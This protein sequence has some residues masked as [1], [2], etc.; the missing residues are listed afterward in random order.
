MRD[1][2]Q[3]NF[4]I[5]YDFRNPVPW[6]RDPTW[7]YGALVDQ[8]VAAEALGYD[9]VWIS[10]HH[11][12]EDGYCPAAFPVLGALA[13]RT[14]QVTLGTHVLLLP[15]HHP[16]R[17]AE[18]SAVADVLSHGRLVLGAGAGYRPEEFAIYQIPRG[19]R[20]SRMDEALEI[21]RLA[22]SEDCFSFVGQHF[23]FRDVTVRPRPAQPDGIPI[24]LGARG[25]RAVQRAVRL[26]APLL[27]AGGDAW[28]SYLEAWKE[29][30][31][32]PSRAVIA[33]QW[34][35]YVA[36]DGKKAWDDVKQHLLYMENSYAGWFRDAGDLP[37]DRVL[38]PDRTVEEL[39]PSDYC[40][41]DPQQVRERIARLIAE[42]PVHTLIMR[43]QFPGLDPVKSLRS[44]E[45]FARYVAPALHAAGRAT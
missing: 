42:I 39:R 34:P 7:L 40:I 11:F 14:R 45:L 13:A 25:R 22:W 26:G 4:G 27:S 32:D 33:V 3:V 36:E 31:R 24:W 35:V 18:D 30:G 20:G 29:H 37:Q 10:Q 19:Q 41:G 21:L 44:M 1:G 8:A 6:H 5:L 15:L 38:R 16:L 9:S 23:R 43:M 12:T 2:R 17:V 28:R